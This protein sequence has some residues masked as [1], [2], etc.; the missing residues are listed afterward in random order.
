M[1]SERINSIFVTFGAGRTGWRQAAK[2]ISREARATGIFSEVIS[3]DEQWLKDFSPKSYAIVNQ[4]QSQNFYKGFGYMIW[5]PLIFKW[6][7]KQYPN[8]NILYMDSGSHIDQNSQQIIQLKNLLCENSK[9]GLAWAL[10]NHKEIAWSKK[11]L[12]LRMNP[13]EKILQSG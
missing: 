5:K 1:F 2:R 10:P 12:V 4:F 13:T 3:L 8:L 11:E 7:M 9:N 6:I